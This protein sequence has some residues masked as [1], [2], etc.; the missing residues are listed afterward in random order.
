MTE[1]E[2]TQVPIGAPLNAAV[3]E[4]VMGFQWWRSSET[5]KR[6]LFHPHRKPEWFDVRATA[7]ENLATQWDCRILSY[8]IDPAA[9]WR[10]LEKMRAAD[11]GVFEA[12][13]QALS[14]LT[15]DEVFG[16]TIYSAFRR[17]T[18]EIIWPEIIC[19]AALIAHVRA[20]RGNR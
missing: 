13:I 7:T 2:I 8:S 20:E 15:A 11:L 3:A 10:V 9:A 16:A 6:A 18:P 5:G 12:F 19:R 4:H 1:Q 17:L 14:R